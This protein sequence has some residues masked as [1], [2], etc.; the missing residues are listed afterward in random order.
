MER[1]EEDGP[2]TCA[3]RILDRL[4]EAPELGYGTS[5]EEA[6][7][8]RNRLL[9][10]TAYLRC[11]DCGTAR[12]SR[13]A[14]LDEHPSCESCGSRFLTMPSGAQERLVLDLKTSGTKV[15][16]RDAISKL[17]WKADLISIYGKKAITA[18]SVRG[19]GP[20]TASRILSKMHEQD[21]EFVVDL[22]RASG[23]YEA[24]KRYWAS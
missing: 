1:S 14:D 19:I 23:K 20:Q 9:G 12:R 22:I 7:K 16:S 17:K 4:A 11:Y 2:T 24:T 5:K 13:I 3:K 10:R 18:L 15:E 8:V 21:D 6:E